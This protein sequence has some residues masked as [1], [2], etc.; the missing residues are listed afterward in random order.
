MTRRRKE[1]PASVKRDA[2]DRCTDQHGIPRCEECTA[3]LSAANVH[4]DGRTDGEFDHDYPDALNGEPTLANCVVRCRTC[5]ARKTKRDR[6]VIAKSN[7]VR[8]LARGI[9]QNF[10]RPLLGTKRSGIKLPFNR[11]GPILRS[12][13]Q[14]LWR[15]RT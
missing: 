2:W 10:Y 9:K 12:T 3:R 14:L 6:K 11:T 5:H 4:Y 8:D 1:F 15:P 13:G 7:H